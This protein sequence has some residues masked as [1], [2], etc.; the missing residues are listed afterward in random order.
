MAAAS[1]WRWIPT[2]YFAQGLPYVVVMTLSVVMYKN[3]GVSNTEIA[4][5]TS[6]L[7]LP[8][9]IKPLCRPATIS[10]NMRHGRTLIAMRENRPVPHGSPSFS[11]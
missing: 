8:W 6:W 2:L 4:L 1:P 7:Y 9:V 10:A 3:L 5:Y 11:R